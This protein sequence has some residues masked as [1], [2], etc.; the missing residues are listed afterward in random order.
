MPKSRSVVNFQ[1]NYEKFVSFA[2][3]STEK[4]SRKMLLQ[5]HKTAKT[6]ATPPQSG[7]TESGLTHD[8]KASVRP[9]TSAANPIHKR[10]TKT[11]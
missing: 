8:L 3:F 11:V 5:L 4:F 2:L 9:Q 6:R 1:K 10:V 7:W